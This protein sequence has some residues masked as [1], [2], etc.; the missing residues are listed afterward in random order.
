MFGL[1][2]N[3]ID[4]IIEILK[5]FK[6]IK[7]AVIF[8]SRAKGNYKKASDIDIALFGDDLHDT[9]LEI[10]GK[11][12]DEGPLPFK[13]DVIDYNAIDNSLLKDHIDR[14]GI[15]CYSIK[16]SKKIE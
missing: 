13:V 2:Q 5:P 10:S 12:N 11:L 3:D 15:E 1:R 14:I 6:A 4:Y 9:V 8:G 7:K 16:T